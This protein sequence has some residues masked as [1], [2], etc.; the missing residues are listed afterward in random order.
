MQIL[1]PYQ[2][3]AIDLL[4]Q[5]IQQGKK[6][7][8]VVSPTGSGKTTLASE[9]IKRCVEK[10]KKA[11]FI[12]HRQELV[13]QAHARFAEFGINA[14]II[15]PPHTLANGH[16]VHV[17][18]IQ[19][20]IRREHPPADVIFIDE[21]HHSTANSYHSIIKN[22]PDAILIGLT[23]TPYR[24]DGKGLG[25]IYGDIIVSSTIE[26]L[27][28]DKY[29]VQPRYFGAK[30]DFSDIHIQAGDYNT[31]ELFQKMDEKVLY[32]GVVEKFKQFGSG[33]TLIFCVNIEHSTKTTRAFIDAG[34]KAMHF[35]CDT[36]NADRKIILDK[37]RRGD[38]D[39]LSNVAICTEG[40]D[41]PAINTVILNRATKSKCLF[42]QM[43]GRALRP[44]EGKEH[45]I[46]IDHGNNVYEHGAVEWEEEYS[47]EGIKKKKKKSAGNMLER[48]KE[49]PQCKELLHI[50][51]KSCPGCGYIF[52][53][54]EKLIQADFEELKLK[55]IIIP[56]H[57]RKPWSK[58]S[59][60]ELEE[61]RVLKG[62]KK[63]WLWYQ[64]KL[65]NERMVING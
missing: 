16:D 61:Y 30:K 49:C 4:K 57:L 39:I 6:R 11:L 24:M 23:A 21:S 34:Y 35:D 42:V 38:I 47:L 9:I 32:D 54:E 37:F 43:V 56:T 36:K 19:T 53:V 17:A 20:L 31:K 10:G 7:I 51:C 28:K 12:A 22:Y 8:V 64:R 58:M 26:K 48:V 59:D 18:S 41:L 40:F 62:Y 29:L 60:E 25:N 50:R 44:S 14:G 52:P 5:K 15:M 45:A 13:Y 55:K 65:R 2:H 3:E 27:I 33:K 46:I 1:R 63:G